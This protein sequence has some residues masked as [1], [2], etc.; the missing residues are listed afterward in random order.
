MAGQHIKAF[1]AVD[2]T[3]GVLHSI[4]TA[5]NLITKVTTVA[6]ESMCGARQTM[7][8]DLIAVSQARLHHT[9]C[10]LDLL[11]QPVHIGRDVFVNLGDVG[12]NHRCEQ[13]TADAWCR[14][15]GQD[16]MT[17]SQPPRR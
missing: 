8:V 6:H 15:D 10:S 12:G 1:E 17:E 16:E 5:V 2:R 4:A 11:Q 7:T 3:E 13:H 9:I 14:L